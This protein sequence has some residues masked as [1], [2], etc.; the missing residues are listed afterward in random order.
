V[1]T[2]ESF[3]TVPFLLHGTPLLAMLPRRLGERLRSAADITLFDLPFELPRLEEK[4]VWN[5]RFSASPA[6]VWMREQ[7]ISVAQALT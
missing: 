3:T 2:T 6:H 5:P 1:A 4:L 7:I